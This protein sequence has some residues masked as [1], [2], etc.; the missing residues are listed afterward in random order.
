MITNCKSFLAQL[1]RVKNTISGAPR[2]LA[3]TKHGVSNATP[4]AISAS[5]SI[6]KFFSQL[7]Q[8][9]NS[10]PPQRRT[11]TSRSSSMAV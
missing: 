1:C 4:C 5:I 6:A 8:T 2:S 3:P 10:S 9:Q 11:S 7:N